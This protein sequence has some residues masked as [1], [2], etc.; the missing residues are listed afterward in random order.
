MSSATVIGI[1]GQ[2]VVFTPIQTLWEKETDQRER[3]PR[4]AWWKDIKD[5]V[6]ILSGRSIPEIVAASEI[7]AGGPAKL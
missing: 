6:N 3:R 2:S 1:R 4:V 5:N 7:A